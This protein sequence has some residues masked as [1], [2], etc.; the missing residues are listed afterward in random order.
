VKSSEDKFF[1]KIEKTFSPK[2][3]VVNSL[4]S[5]LERDPSDRFDR[6]KENIKRQDFKDFIVGYSNWGKNPN[7]NNNDPTP[8][9]GLRRKLHKRMQTV[10]I[11][12]HNTSNTNP[13]T[14]E[15][16]T[17]EKPFVGEKQIQKHHLLRCTNEQ[18]PCRWWNRNVVGSFNILDNFSKLCGLKE[19]LTT[20]SKD[21]RLTR[22]LH[23]NKGVPSLIC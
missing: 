6:I 12:E 3:D 11:Q 5:W 2:D 22:C 1:N 18:S 21:N 20:L 8:G 9:I 23:A 16:K 4:P 14:Q 15:T 17:M 10:T 7:L 19:S 13:C